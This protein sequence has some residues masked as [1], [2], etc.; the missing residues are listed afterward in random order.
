MIVVVMGVSGSGKT[1]I[2]KQLAARQGWRFADADAFHPSANVEKMRQGVPLTDADRAPWLAAV[3][4]ALDA[5]QAAGESGVLACSALKQT[6]R[7]I[8]S[9]QGDAVF[10]HLRGS[11][12]VIGPRMR[13]RT[14]HYMNPGLLA[15]QFEILEPPHDAITVDVAFSVD[16]LVSQILVRLPPQ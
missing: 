15:S 5:W 12:E 13:E 11:P 4:D 6:Y 1:T 14:G 8:L 2:G 16:E 3:R 9:P 10:V 7:E